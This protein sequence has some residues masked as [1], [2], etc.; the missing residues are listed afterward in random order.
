V[1]AAVY[2]RDAEAG[3]QLAARDERVARVLADPASYPTYMQAA[4]L[5]LIELYRRGYRMGWDSL[6]CAAFLFRREQMYEAPEAQ[7]VELADDMVQDALAWPE[8]DVVRIVMP[9][10]LEP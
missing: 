7:A 5:A 10:E 9:G 8:V 4:A 3:R 6:L 1:S 2:H